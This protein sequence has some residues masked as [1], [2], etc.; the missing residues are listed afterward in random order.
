MHIPKCA[1]MYVNRLYNLHKH[2]Y[3]VFFYCPALLPSSLCTLVGLPARR[4]Y[5]GNLTPVFSRL[6][7][8]H[9]FAS[10]ARLEPTTHLEFQHETETFSFAVIVV[11]DLTVLFVSCYITKCSVSKDDTVKLF[12]TLCEKLTKNLSWFFFFFAHIFSPLLLRSLHGNEIS[13]LPDGIFMDVASLSH[14]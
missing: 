11:V 14:L 10:C 13:E 6:T 3:T 7:E 4:T 9:I 2:N 5:C 12:L 1:C 8:P